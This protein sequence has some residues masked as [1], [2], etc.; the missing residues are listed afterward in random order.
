MHIETCHIQN[1][2]LFRTRNI[3]KACQTWTMIRH[4]QSQ[5]SLIKNF[6]RYLG[7]YKDYYRHYLLENKKSDFEKR[8]TDS[9]HLWVKFSIPNVVLRVYT[10]KISNMFLWGASFSY[11]LTKYLLKCPSSQNSSPFQNFPD[12]G[13]FNHIQRY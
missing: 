2:G 9:V 11:V 10:R 7:I 13:I 3:I 6:Q 1:P 12:S 4:I 5:N 8:D